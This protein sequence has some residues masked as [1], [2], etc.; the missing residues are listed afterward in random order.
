LIFDAETSSPVILSDTSTEVYTSHPL[1]F[2]RCM[3]WVLDDGPVQI[4][5]PGEPPPEAFFTASRFVAHNCAFERGLWRHKLI[6]LGWPE[7]PPLEYWCDTMV[8]A[9]V[10]ALPGE[11]AKVTKLLDLPHQKAAGDIMRLMSRPRPPRP[12]EDPAIYHWDDDPEHLE[13]LCD[14]C[15][16]DTLCERELYRFCLRHLA[17][18]SSQPGSGISAA[19]KT[20]STSINP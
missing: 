12:G 7:V 1:T 6:P 15:E 8:L 13:Q 11:L 10:L 16:R 14:Y 19:M 9:L 3:A 20:G 2:L 4:W 5:R 18:S 17:I